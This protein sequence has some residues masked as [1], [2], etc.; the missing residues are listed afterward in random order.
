MKA[1][2]IQKIALGLLLDLAETGLIMGPQV[3]DRRWLPSAPPSH[4]TG[5]VQQSPIILVHL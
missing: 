5:Q 2:N 4:W 1:S 3:I